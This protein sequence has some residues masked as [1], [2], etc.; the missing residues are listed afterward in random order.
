MI[1]LSQ[2]TFKDDINS[3]VKKVHSNKASNYISNELW[4]QVQKSKSQIIYPFQ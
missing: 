3:A 2:Y 4:N 1:L